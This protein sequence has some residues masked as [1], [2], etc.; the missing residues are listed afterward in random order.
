MYRCYICWCI[1]FISVIF[2]NNALSDS[3]NLDS[4][5]IELNKEELS[6][7]LR[8]E[9]LIKLGTETATTDQVLAI[10]FVNQAISL[11][12]KK[13]FFKQ[14][15]NAYHRL[16]MIHYEKS[17]F[18]ETDSNLTKAVKYRRD[19]SDSLGLASS[20]RMLGV[21]NY[22]RGE[23]AVALTFTTEALGIFNKI[24]DTIG[25]SNTLN[26][27]GVFYDKQDDRERA[28]E[29]YMQAIEMR[30]LAGQE[31]TIAQLLNNV[32]IIYGRNE[33]FSTAYKY[34]Q[35]AVD[36]ARENNQ[37]RLLSAVYVNIAKISGMEGNYTKAGNYYMLALEIKQQ[38]GDL[39]GMAYLY[40]G[41]AENY[42]S[43]KLY[44]K[45]FEAFKKSLSICEDLAM[46]DLMQVILKD[47]STLF[48]ETN[49]FE[50][51]YEYHLRFFENFK[52]SV[53]EEN[54]N[55]I[56]EIKAGFDAEKKASEIEMLT[57]E[58][59]LQNKQLSRNRVYIILLIIAIGL[60]L[61]IS[62][63]AIIAYKEKERY[64][65]FAESINRELE[66]RV[67]R[68]VDENRKKD[69]MLAQQ[70]KQAVM[71]EMI[72]NIAH[73]WRQPLNSLGIIIQN[74]EEAYSFGEV[75]AEYLND[76]VLKS[77]NLIKY[78]DQTIDD[79]RYFFKPNKVKEHFEVKEAV[80][81]TLEFAEEAIKKQGIKIE[82]NI[83]N[84]VFAS[85]FSNEYS[86]VVLNILNNS[87]DALVGSQVNNPW[88]KVELTKKD[89][90]SLLTIEDNAGG[91]KES[92][93]EKIFQPYFTSKESTGG[94][95]LGL[96][97][98]RIIIEKNM[99][100][101]LTAINTDNGARFY[102]LV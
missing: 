100:G 73:Q 95:G 9:L 101:K 6:D 61:I 24:Q 88:I 32:A 57:R 94:T 43:Q 64:Y 96:Y 59:E 72:N 3:S 16:A 53:D 93:I 51:A 29:Y 77:M 17:N 86:Q 67:S 20:L 71:G 80:K 34:F 35:Q 83:D 19:V 70:N 97:M 2:A 30:K 50:Q 56:A 33:D 82:A 63:F 15:G 11:A 18:P 31:H 78:M 28:L 58:K 42:K 8:I 23:F 44:D 89:R 52:E 26:D 38:I 47:L 36:Y 49:Q 41:Q 87:K 92:D 60:V 102:I 4:L 81:R 74:I 85:G 55:K 45:A 21:I 76:K 98:S 7:S 14:L 25:I 46:K 13:Q 37:L 10:E 5:K 68:E 39:W 54:R 69:I 48:A 65:K 75:N 62:F 99:D 12:Q 66:D 40:F 91:I 90:K 27:L 22:I 79:F 84:E 1:V